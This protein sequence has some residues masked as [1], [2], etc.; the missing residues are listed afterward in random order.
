MQDQETPQY[1]PPS[2]EE[3]ETDGETVATAPGVTTGR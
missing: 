1:E 2:V 3:I